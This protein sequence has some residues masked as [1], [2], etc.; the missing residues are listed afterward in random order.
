MSRQ[1]QFGAQNPP[2]H[3]TT[4]TPRDTT[5]PSD[6]KPSRQVQPVHTN[7]SVSQKPAS[8]SPTTPLLSSA[9]RCR[10]NGEQ[11]VQTLIGWQ[12]GQGHHV[13]FAEPAHLTTGSIK[14]AD[15]CG[16][17]I[18]G[19]GVDAEAQAHLPVRGM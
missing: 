3:R 19:E 1:M 17:R 9:H 16:C 5:T 13:F 4:Y 8:E 11:G 12:V 7:R 14:R 18:D 2:P 15:A 10:K 6:T